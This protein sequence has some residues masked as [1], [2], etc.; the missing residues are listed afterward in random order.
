MTPSLCLFRWLSAAYLTAAVVT[1][2]TTTLTRSYSQ[3]AVRPSVRSSGEP[4]GI[5]RPT[6]CHPSGRPDGTGP[7]PHV[8]CYAIH[9]TDGRALAASRPATV[10]IRRRCVV[11]VIRST[12][13]SRRSAAGPLVRPQP[14]GFPWRNIVPDGSA[15]IRPVSINLSSQAELHRQTDAEAQR[16][17]LAINHC[18]R[19]SLS[20]QDVVQSSQPTPCHSHGL[21][22]SAISSYRALSSASRAYGTTKDSEWF[23]D[24]VCT[25]IEAKLRIKLNSLRRSWYQSCRRPVVARR[26]TWR[27]AERHGWDMSVEFPPYWG[28]VPRRHSVMLVLGLGLDHHCFHI[29]WTV[30]VSRLIWKTAGG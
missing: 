9:Q 16:R 19:C 22:H 10:S 29:I 1:T 23:L 18:P 7:D 2:P 12:I 11:V 8:C 14:T 20:C 25:A 24:P 27:P 15:Y 3:V 17:R 13:M 4:P 26:R 30:S 28:G 21:H 6:A 5:D